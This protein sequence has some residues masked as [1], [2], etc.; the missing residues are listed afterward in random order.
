MRAFFLLPVQNKS[1]TKF[2]YFSKFFS[3]LISHEVF[4]VGQLYDYQYNMGLL[5]IEKKEWALK[6]EELGEALAETQEILKRE[7]SA[8]LISISEVEKREE[9]LRKVLVA[10]KQCVAE[11]CQAAFIQF[12]IFNLPDF[13]G[14]CV[15]RCTFLPLLVSQFVCNFLFGLELLI[16]MCSFTAAGK[17]FA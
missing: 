1:C 17:S 3:F 4:V 16:W 15:S 9:N 6:H 12:Y 8:H 2:L 13:Y 11:V 10:E 7:Q 5:L 14:T